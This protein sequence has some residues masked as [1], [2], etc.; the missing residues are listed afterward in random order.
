MLSAE[1]KNNHVKYILHEVDNKQLKVE[2]AF[3][4]ACSASKPELKGK[5]E[6][7]WCVVNF[8]SKVIRENI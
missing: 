6:E 4:K 3:L 1:K 7:S 2:E 5:F 8:L